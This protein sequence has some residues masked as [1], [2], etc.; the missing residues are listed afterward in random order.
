MQDSC[1]EKS[2]IVGSVY[3]FFYFGLTWASVVCHMA[4]CDLIDSSDTIAEKI[5][6][7]AETVSVRST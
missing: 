6:N 1:R 5:D 7:V 4:E 3:F 2:L